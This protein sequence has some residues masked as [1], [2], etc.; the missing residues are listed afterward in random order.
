MA[1]FGFPGLGLLLAQ[2]LI[3]AGCATTQTNDQWLEHSAR[4]N[5]RTAEVW[6]KAG[7]PSQATKFEQQAERDR[8]AAKKKP[9]SFLEVI[10]DSL[11][12]GWSDEPRK[13]NQR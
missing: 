12:I 9:T 2:S 8:Q 10:L 6:R 3:V 5:E 7:E 13:S 11:L 1:Q 4:E